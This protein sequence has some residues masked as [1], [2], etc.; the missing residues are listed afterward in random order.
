MHGEK[1]RGR[2]VLLHTGGIDS[3]EWLLIH[4]RDKHAVD[5]WDPEAHPRSVISGLTNEE[6]ALG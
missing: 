6:V 2:L 1:L 5:G 4:K 3:N